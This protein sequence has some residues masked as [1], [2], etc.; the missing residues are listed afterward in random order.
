MLDK[1][2]SWCKENNT[3]ISALE[4][5]C[6]LGNGTIGGWEKSSPR[7]DTLLAVSKITGIEISELA[8]EKINT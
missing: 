6:G 8:E 3:S 4:K 5:K 7:I 2:R 1:I